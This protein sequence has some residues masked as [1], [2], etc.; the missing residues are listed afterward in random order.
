[1]TRI[2]V[3]KTPSRK[4]VASL[5]KKIPAEDS[6]PKNIPMVAPNKR[7]NLSAFRK[8]KTTENKITRKPNPANPNGGVDVSAVQTVQKTKLR[9]NGTVV[10]KNK[11]RFERNYNNPRSAQTTVSKTKSV[12]K[13]GALVKTKGRVKMS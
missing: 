9:K 4:Q 6:A 8:V 10:V 1:M 7:G 12:Y 3:F 5:G 2:T 11:S 13:N